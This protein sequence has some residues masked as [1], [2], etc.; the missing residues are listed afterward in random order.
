MYL[1]PSVGHC[2]I[3]VKYYAM[4]IVLLCTLAMVKPVVNF[5]IFE[6][7]VVEPQLMVTV[8]CNQDGIL[9]NHLSVC[10]SVNVTQMVPVSPPSSP[11]SCGV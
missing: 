6:F 2:T 10:A 7:S 9:R 3:V 4:S 1:T 8:L 5:F 11:Y